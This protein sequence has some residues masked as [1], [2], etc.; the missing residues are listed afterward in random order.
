MSH[1]LEI[2]THLRLKT[3]HQKPQWHFPKKTLWVNS[4]KQKPITE[5][6]YRCHFALLK[7]M[8]IIV[9]AERRTLVTWLH[10]GSFE[11]TPPSSTRGPL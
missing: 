7:M 9:C 11:K 6:R 3:L 5:V 2:H 10:K 4:P 1:F 8:T